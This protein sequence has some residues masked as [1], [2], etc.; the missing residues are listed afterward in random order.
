MENKSDIVYSCVVD[1]VKP[2]FTWQCMVFVTCLLELCHVK[3]QNIIIH[4]IGDHP[5]LKLFLDKR[6]IKYIIVNRFG[7]GKYCNKLSQLDSALFL[8]KSK[9]IALCDCDIAFTAP[10]SDIIT[11]D[12]IYG[13]TVNLSLPPLE[14]VEKLFEKYALSF[15]GLV[16]TLSGYTFSGNF[17]GG[18]YIG[19]KNI[20]KALTPYWKAYVHSILHDDESLHIL[21]RWRNHIDQLSFCMAVCKSGIQTQ[22]LPVEYNFPLPMFQKCGISLSE[23][24]KLCPDIPH[25]SGIVKVVHY[26]NLLDENFC[27]INNSDDLRI[28]TPMNNINSVIEKLKLEIV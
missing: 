17:N 6:K 13:K 1:D 24:H 15:P 23:F 21:G 22:Y 27:I 18:L 7:D 20:F 2:I 19:E 16:P 5:A 11:A 12:K 26:H 9:Y 14:I 25:T 8:S 10:I 4:L 28:V 3:H